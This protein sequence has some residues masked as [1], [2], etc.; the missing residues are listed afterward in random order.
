MR[1]VLVLLGLLFVT[2]TQAERDLD[3]DDNLVGGEEE[4]DSEDDDDLGISAISTSLFFPNYEG[5]RIPAGKV[6]DVIATVASIREEDAVFVIAIRGYLA[7]PFKE[8]EALVNFTLQ[9]YNETVPYGT[10]HAF[11]YRFQVAPELEPRDYRCVLELFYFDS[12]NTT[13]LYPLFN[14]TLSFAPAPSALDFRMVGT[15]I[16]FLV[17]LAAGGYTAYLTLVVPKRRSAPRATSSLRPNETGNAAITGD[18]DDDDVLCPDHKKFRSGQ[19]PGK[20]TPRKS[21]TP[22]KGPS[23]SPSKAH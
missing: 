4:E 10:E 22:N 17:L 2:V 11:W 9:F 6:V 23:K 1:G 5:S 21:T 7:S 8:R 12:R 14:G 19:S 16:F 15:W 13:H 18:D 3:D 20:G